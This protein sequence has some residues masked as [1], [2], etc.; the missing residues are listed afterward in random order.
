MEEESEDIDYDIQISALRV[1]EDIDKRQIFDDIRIDF[2][3]IVENIAPEDDASRLNQMLM[4]YYE[5]IHEVLQKRLDECQD[6]IEEYMTQLIESKKKNVQ[7]HMQNLVY[8][9]DGKSNG[10]TNGDKSAKIDIAS[11]TSEHNY[12]LTQLR[13]QYEEFLKNAEAEFF[14][15]LKS[16]KGSSE[17]NSDENELSPREKNFA[18]EYNRSSGNYTK[19]SSSNLSRMTSS[20]N[21]IHD[22]AN[23]YNSNSNSHINRQM[24]YNNFNSSADIRKEINK[25]TPNFNKTDMNQRSLSEVDYNVS[26]ES[27]SD[28]KQPNKSAVNQGNGSKVRTYS[29]ENLPLKMSAAKRI[30]EKQNLS[31]T[32]PVTPPNN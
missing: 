10:R 28:E 29:Q 16:V 24:Y 20:Q 8:D 32:Q 3:S 7:K 23:L 1:I 12:R 4:N 19:K 11:I 18:E 14:N 5:E 25:A 2:D 17:F 31:K 21:S 22:K 15:V 30:Q 9:N 27:I 13:E 6:I 26:S